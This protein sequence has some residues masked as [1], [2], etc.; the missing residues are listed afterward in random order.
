MKRIVL[1]SVL[2]ASVCLNG[3]TGAEVLS[4]DR[5]R[6]TYDE[7]GVA[8]IGSPQDPYGAQV[9]SP[10]RPLGLLLR[11]RVEQG[12]WQDVDLRRSQMEASAQDGL[13][14]YVLSDPASPLCVVQSFS[15]NDRGLDWDIE[16]ETTTDKPVTIGDLAITIPVVGPSGRTPQQIFE[17]GF[18]GHQFVSGSGSF[19]YY[20]RASGAP[21]FLIVTVKPGTHL[22][23]FSG[24]RGGGALYVHSGLSGGDETRG[25]WR[26]EHTFVMLGPA[27]AGDSKTRYGFRF[28]F[29]S[30]YDG[31]RD[32]LY[33]EGLFDVR[34]VPG[35]TIPE[36]L[37]ARFALCTRA[38]I[39]AIKAEFPDSTRIE[40]LGEKQP[41][42][43]VYE[44]T[45]KRLGENKLTIQH[46]GGRETYLEYFVTE[47]LE[48]LIK[49]RASFLVRR[50][51]IRDSNHWWDGVFGPYDMK[52]EVVRTVDDPDIFLDRMVYVLTCDDPGLCKAPFVASKN[53]SFPNKEE[54]EG[55]EYYLEHFVWGKLQRTDEEEP[56]P[57]GVYGT[58]HWHINRDPQRRRAYAESLASN[59]TALRD[60]NKEHVWRSY[61]YP[62][63]VMLYFHMYEIAKKYPSMSTYL[64]AAGYL[65]RAFQTARA[66]YRYP[67]EIYPSYYETYKWGLYNELVVL[68]LIEALEAEGFDH[69]ADW[70][71]AEWEKKVKYFVYDDEY[72][73]RSEYAFDRTAFES[74]Y[75]F[76]KYGATHDMEADRHLWWD[77]KNEKWYSHP[78]VRREDS[79]L[80]MDRQLAAGLCVRGWLN[81]AYYRLGADQGVSYMAAMG[82]SGILDYA[83]NFADDPFDWLQL[84]YA[85]YLSSWCLMNTG[86]ADTDYGF[87][88][89]GKANDGAAGWQFMSAKVGNAWMGSS[90]PGGVQVPRGPWHYDGEIDLGFGGALRMA[91]TVVTRDPVFDWFA[92]GGTLRQEADTLSAVPRDGLRQ[93]FAVVLPEVRTPWPNATRFKIELDQDGFMPERPILLDQ[94]LNAVRFTLENRTEDEHV[95]TL[96]LGFHPSV[97]YDVLQ[98]GQRV[99]LTKTD[100]RDYPWQAQLQMTGKPSKIDI[101]RTT[102]PGP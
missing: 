25:T 64:D 26:Q 50:Q 65:E 53:V 87:W 55:L 85:S 99:A 21:P 88:F 37:S 73:F 92:Y 79:R 52:N 70:L 33:R 78:Q 80:F 46:D 16:L 39:D 27:G 97:T 101:I 11:Y 35:M 75:A 58:P 2:S 17:R 4:G 83:I 44:A 91:A 96:R 42:T 93:R 62:H 90:Y 48:T 31:L 68:D 43:Y 69:Q 66:F 5:I 100:N 32:V 29:A 1:L 56:Y 84:G 24:G 12:Q 51:Q 18:M 22:E 38:S 8:G 54:I 98:D 10:Q 89:P 59:A 20:V 15:T 7:R 94:R 6:V 36:D 72:P 28:Q 19:V 81:P 60:L 63:V 102:Q 49:K 34:A 45:F 86:R 82:G 57:Y 61:D 14:R 67:Y 40:F 9:T 3:S 47:P 74:T 76:A 23:Y 30:S 71:R 41:D 77:V 13:V 95:T